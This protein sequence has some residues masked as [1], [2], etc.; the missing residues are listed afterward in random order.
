MPG[1]FPITEEGM[2]LSQALRKDI[3]AFKYL[4]PFESIIYA[5]GSAI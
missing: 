1:V 2:P 3:L 4:T 5:P